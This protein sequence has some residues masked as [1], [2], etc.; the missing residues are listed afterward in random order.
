M[1]NFIKISIELFVL[2]KLS[3]DNFK[4]N[5]WVTAMSVLITGALY[6]LLDFM[7]EQSFLG[8]NVLLAVTVQWIN[9]VILYQFLK[10]WLKRSSACDQ[11]GLVNV[12]GTSILIS[13]LIPIILI[14][15][16]LP[17]ILLL[18]ALLALA[19]YSIYVVGYSVSNVY[20]I[21]LGYT[22]K[23]VFLVWV[24]QLIVAALS[25]E[26]RD[27]LMSTLTAYS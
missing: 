26:L 17:A 18:I 27:N 14:T 9:F 16:Q 6:G 22:L 12:L 4:F 21:S 25:L 1:L 23:G 8:L 13:N 11:G 7:K 2:K 20:E 19:A 5:S 3:I 15:M 10:W 24:I